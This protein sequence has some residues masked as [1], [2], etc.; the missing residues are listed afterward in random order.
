MSKAALIVASTCCLL[1]ALGL[2]L[3]GSPAAAF[4]ALGVSI[5]FDVGYVRRLLAEQRGAREAR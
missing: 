4:V 5:V 2:Y 3:A 1:L